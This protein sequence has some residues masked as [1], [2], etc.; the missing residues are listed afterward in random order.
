[1]GSTP[2]YAIFFKHETVLVNSSTLNPVV[3]GLKKILPY[4]SE[5]GGDIFVRNVG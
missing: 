4:D 5:D 1:M 2:N 3:T